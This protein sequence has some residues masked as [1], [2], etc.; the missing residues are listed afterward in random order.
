VLETARAILGAEEALFLALDP[1]TRRLVAREASTSST[2]YQGTG[3]SIP[4]GAG[5]AGAVAQTRKPAV[6]PGGNTA[7]A[8]LPVFPEPDRATGIAVPFFSQGNLFGVVGAY[9]RRLGG[10]FQAEDVETLATLVRQAETAIDNAFLHEEAQRLSITDGLTGLWNRRELELRCQQETDRAARFGRPMGM[11]MCDVDRFKAVND[12]WGHLGGDA[13]LI[14]L[15]RRLSVA[16]REID[17]VARYGG[18][19]FALVLPETNL[20]GACVLAEKIRAAVSATPIEHEGSLRTVTMSL[21]VATYPLH[22]RTVRE[23]LTSADAA[24]YRAKQGGRNR[25]CVAED[26]EARGIA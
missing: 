16:T 10:S 22:G 15:A 17:V 19:E 25:M 5:L 20:E 3:W 4:V 13:V 9:G 12:S 24:L 2:G 26:P 14:E 7:L 18:E 1:A 6:H 23:L 21:G 11:I 8:Y